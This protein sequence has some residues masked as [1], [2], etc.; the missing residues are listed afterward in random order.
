MPAT[1]RPLVEKR[2]AYKREARALPEGEQRE[3]YTRRATAHKWL[4]VTCFGYLGYKNA[5][6]GRI[7]AHE[8]V[9]A[10]GREMLLRAK[11][12]AEAR[13]FRLLHAYVDSVWIHRPGP[14]P[15]YDALVAEIESATGL[16]IA[17]EGVYRWVAFL[18]SRVDPR[19]SVAN[20]YFGA[21]ES[22]EVKMRG[23]EARRHDTPLW[24]HAAQVAMI[25]LLAPG[26]DAAGFRARLP[27]VI[28][29]ARERLGEL[30]AGRVP[31][32]DLTIR[33]RL[34]REPGELRANTAGVTAARQLA[35][36]GV[37]LSAGEMIRY[38]LVRGP[39]RGVAWECAE[40]AEA[41]VDIARY[42]D[43]FLRALET[44]GAPLGVARPT[45]DLWLSANAGYL[46]P[47]GE[48][49]AR[50]EDLAAPL[51]AGRRPRR[52]PRLALPAR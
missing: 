51:L 48:L 5:R 50:A 38:V 23:I 9:T 36:R 46:A 8:A 17:L 25:Q 31:L 26:E 15:D 2:L 20:R 41:R 52:T 7:E 12:V 43:L 40:G 49:P 21:F 10:Y 45:L 28:A 3:T 39:E 47:P 1:L 30:R 22:G 11:E 18:P 37:K 4:L 27:E 42:M 24:I 19:Q 35:A 14:R 33:T 6:F 16:P 29:Y 44:V 13:G 32:A 34:S